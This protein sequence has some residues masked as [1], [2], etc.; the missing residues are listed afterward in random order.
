MEPLKRYSNPLQ[1][2]RKIKPITWLAVFPNHYLPFSIYLDWNRIDVVIKD[3]VKRYAMPKGFYITQT[4]NICGQL[5]LS[6]AL[7]LKRD[8]T[9]LERFAFQKETFRKWT[10]WNITRIVE[11]KD[12]TNSQFIIWNKQIFIVLMIF[13]WS[14]LMKRHS[15]IAC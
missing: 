13:T 15:W 10:F 1:N 5:Q 14:F 4:V 8:A 2:S 12:S 9:S 7:K 3:S 6:E 11:L